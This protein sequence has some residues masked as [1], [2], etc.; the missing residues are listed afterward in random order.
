MDDFFLPVLG[1]AG[2]AVFAAAGALAASRKQMDII[3]F[4]FLASIT[5]VG[6]GTIRDLLLGKNPVFWVADPSQLGVCL[7]VAVIVYFT[8]HLAES[9]YRLL[10]WADAVGLAA[11]AVLG[12]AEALDR[13]AGPLAAVAVGVL[14]ATSGGIIR[15]VTSGEPSVLMRKELYVTAALAGAVVYVGLAALGLP[16]WPAGLAASAVAFGVR[17]GALVFAWTLPG[18]RQRPGRPPGTA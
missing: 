15:D 4:A 12:A 7:A 1:Y 13:S 14:T 16:R 2:V 11:Y 10:L 6:G 9:R 17:A 8:A 5:G 18:Y 3:G